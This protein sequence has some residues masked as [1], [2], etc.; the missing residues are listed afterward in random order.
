MEL[1]AVAVEPLIEQLKASLG[2]ASTWLSKANKDRSLYKAALSVVNSKAIKSKSTAEREE[3]RDSMRLL[4]KRLNEFRTHDRFKIIEPYRHL[5][6]PSHPPSEQFDYKKLKHRALFWGFLFSYHISEF[7]AAVL[8]V[9]D[10]QEAL[11]E[12]RPKASFWWPSIPINFKYFARKQAAGGDE[13]EDVSDDTDP[14][15]MTSIKT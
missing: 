7:S 2:T 1:L 3:H 13:S 14:G 15:E 8:E 12:L 4:E 6:D 11:D 9:L 5:L 10:K